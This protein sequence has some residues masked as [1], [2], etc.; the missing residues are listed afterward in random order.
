VKLTFLLFILGA[1]IAPALPAD[2]LAL[3][4]SLADEQQHQADAILFFDGAERLYF[5]R[6]GKHNEPFPITALA[7]RV[8]AATTRRAMIVVIM[9]RPT[10]M[11]PDDR[12]KTA[13]DD[14]E[15]RLRTTGFKKV[16]FHLASGGLATP[17]Y[18]E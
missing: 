11:W 3:R 8:T 4:P 13:V 18:R 12:F 5:E 1:L 15:E 7:E 9:S 10:R 2:E 14:L 16:I 6:T 17:I